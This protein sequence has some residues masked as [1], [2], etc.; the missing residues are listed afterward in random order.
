MSPRRRAATE[1]EA[2]LFLEAMKDAA[3]LKARARPPRLAA[4]HDM[5]ALRA[6]PVSMPVYVDRPAPRI[7]GHDDARLRRGQSEPEDRLDLHGM[8]QE[9]AYRSCVRFLK[10]AQIG[11]AHV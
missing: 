10:R 4:T 1:E 9:A 8:T 5:K 3:P 6:L 7:G 11:R 2:S